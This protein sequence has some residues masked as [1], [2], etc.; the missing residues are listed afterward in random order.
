[1]TRFTRLRNLVCCSKIGHSRPPLPLVLL[2]IWCNYLYLPATS[3]IKLHLKDLDSSSQ[4]SKP[5]NQRLENLAVLAAK[6]AI[7]VYLVHALDY[8]YSRGKTICS[9][10]S[11]QGK[12]TQIQSL[13]HACFSKSLF[14]SCSACIDLKGQGRRRS[15][16]VIRRSSRSYQTMQR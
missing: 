2:D 14:L 11:G 13:F 9:L 15:C 7:K 5:M 10:Q 4:I 12:H 16:R 8:C 6:T 1:M 3:K